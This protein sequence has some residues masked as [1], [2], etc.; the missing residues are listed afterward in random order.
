MTTEEVTEV[1]NKIMELKITEDDAALVKKN[2]Q[3]T[4]AVITEAAIVN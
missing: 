4:E 1:Q 2:L 3:V